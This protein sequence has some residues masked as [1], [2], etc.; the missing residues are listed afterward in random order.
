MVAPRQPYCGSR[1]TCQTVDSVPTLKEP[2]LILKYWDLQFLRAQFW[3]LSSSFYLSTTFRFYGHFAPCSDRFQVRLFHFMV[4]S[5]HSYSVKLDA[6][7]AF[8]GFWLKERGIHRSSAL[9]FARGLKTRQRFWLY[10]GTIWLLS[11]MI[12]LGTIWPW[13]E[14]TGYLYNY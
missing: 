4:E 8:F 14:V 13:N 11:G 5:F 3:V 9:V 6:K 12:W 1:A 10:C 7:R 2:Y